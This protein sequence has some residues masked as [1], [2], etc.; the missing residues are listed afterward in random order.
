[1]NPTSTTKNRMPAAILPLRM[2]PKLHLIL[3]LLIVLPTGILADEEKVTKPDLGNS[4]VPPPGVTNGVGGKSVTYDGDRYPYYGGTPDEMLPYRGIEPYY[5]Y[6]TTRLPFRGP[7]ADYPDPTDL[8]SLRVG[9]L[10]PPTYGPEGARGQRTR[11]GVELAF[12]ETNAALKPGEL[13][14]EI[15][16]KA[17][18][19]QWGSAANIAVEFKDEEVLGILGTIDGD[20]THV[21]LRV[22][23]KIETYMIN[24]SDPDPSLTETQIPWL[25]RIFPEERQQCFR[26]ANLIVR[27]RGCKRIAIL[28]EES[29]PGRTAVMHFVNYVRRL[30]YPPVA[31]L[32]HQPGRRDLAEQLSAI[33]AA[34]P[35]A[36]LF[37]GQ[38]EDIGFAAATF[39]KAGIKAQ[40]FGFDRL[41]EDGFAKN[42][43][44]A[45][46]GTT[47]L[48]FFNP[49]R[50]DKPW[51]NFVGRYQKRWGDKPDVYAAYGYDGARLM[52]EAIQ[53]AG[54]NRFRIRHYLA[55][56]D[57]WDG[58]TGHMVF[59]GRWDNIVPMSIAEFREGKWHFQPTLPVTRRDK[60]KLPN[61]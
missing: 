37:H 24:T 56:L 10:S 5:R 43:G 29:R 40:F 48:Y 7:G 1:M 54:P 46:E 11:Q 31:H 2:K 21:A 35:D 41:K 25:T 60:V 17:D 57:E 44:A 12:E 51:Q 32:L 33:K 18:S 15:I 22:A 47:I 30:G 26:L 58:V 8:K 27:K 52:I 9:L 42:A 14:F 61:Q 53:H 19:P 50:T 34:A 3:T 49:D 55:H 39:R 4:E 23:L 6:W 45:A 13:P 59:D 38:P 36:I 20:A 28:R 16:Y